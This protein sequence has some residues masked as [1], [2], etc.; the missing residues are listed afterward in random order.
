[1][2]IASFL[3]SLRLFS[4]DVLESLRFCLYCVLI[5][6]LR[7]CDVAGCLCCARYVGCVVCVCVFGIVLVYCCVVALL[8]VLFCYKSCCVCHDVV[9]VVSLVSFSW[10]CFSC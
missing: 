9:F 10:I 5:P 2:S 3:V 4:S 1:M 8:C 6:C 7:Y